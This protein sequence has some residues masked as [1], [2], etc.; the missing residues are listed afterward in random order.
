MTLEVAIKN[1]KQDLANAAERVVRMIL[2][3]KKMASK[4]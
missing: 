1:S 4:K 2:I 3:G